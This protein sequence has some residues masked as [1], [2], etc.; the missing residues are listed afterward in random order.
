MKHTR[1]QVSARHE[2]AWFRQSCAHCWALA[3]VEK[4]VEVP[5]TVERRVEVA[6]PY[7]KIVHIE[8]PVEKVVYKVCM[9]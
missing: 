3:Q 4:L 8:V 1:V 5:V 2:K 9:L 6:V 7:E